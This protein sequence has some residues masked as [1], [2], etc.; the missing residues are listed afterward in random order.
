MSFLQVDDDTEVIYAAE[1][2]FKGPARFIA[3][4]LRPGQPAPASPRRPACNKHSTSSD[5]VRA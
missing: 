3:P 5:L 2:T 1:F 4:L